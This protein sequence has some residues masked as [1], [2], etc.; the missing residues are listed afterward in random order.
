MASFPRRPWV[1]PAP[2]SFICHRVTAG[3]GLALSGPSA[4]T[5]EADVAFIDFMELQ[6][7]PY[8]D[9]SLGFI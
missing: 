1:L 6:R 5:S 4:V 7:A 3:E 8:A 9:Q 2:S